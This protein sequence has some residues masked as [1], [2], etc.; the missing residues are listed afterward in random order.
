TN[1]AP[2]AV[3]PIP[4]QTAIE[5]QP[6]VNTLSKDTFEDV[7]IGDD[8]TI[9]AL[10]ENG[11]H[12]PDWLS[13]DPIARSFR[14][15]PT[16]ADVGTLRIKVVAT[17][18]AG[19]TAHSEFSMSVENVNDAPVP[20]LHTR[21]METTENE[22]FVFALPADAFSD[23]DAQDAFSLAATLA[24]GTALPDWLLF[25]AGTGALS[26]TPPIGA[27]GPVELSIAAT[28]CAGA[29][30]ALAFRIIVSAAAGQL[31]AGTSDMDT[32][33]G[34]SG[35]DTLNG[36]DGMDV[37][38]GLKGDD[39]YLVD[40][41]ADQVV[42]NDGE[43]ND[44]ILASDTY[45]LPGGVENLTLMG[46]CGGY[47]AGNALD[48][49]LTGNDASNV[50]VGDGGADV[51]LG[52][53]GSDQLFCGS[54][55]DVA[56]GGND[57]DILFGET[58][59]DC[60]FGES[61]DDVVFGD[62]GDDALDG[63]DG[64]D[65]LFG[66]AGTDLLVGGLDRDILYGDAGNDVLEGGDGDDWIFDVDGNNL[67]LA[68]AGT[69][70][71]TGGVSAEVFI[72]EAGADVVTTG[73]G[74]DVIVFNRGDGQDALISEGDSEKTLSLGGGIA[75]GDLSLWKA[76]G[77]LVVEMGAG[78]SIR[79]RDWYS[80]GTS[81]RRVIALQ[82]VSEAM[83]GFDSEAADP[84]VARRVNQFDFIGL[85]DAFDGE[86][87]A[88]PTLDRWTVARALTQFHLGGSDEAALG[89]DLA[90]LYGRDG[91][92]GG[93]GSWAAQE[94]LGSSQMGV[95][96]QTVRARMELQ[97]GDLRLG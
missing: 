89:G 61:G 57:V 85:V 19:S 28:D 6:Y 66:G 10:L 35:N 51:L 36:G 65:Q 30:G 31:L 50:L 13:F 90:Y 55:N 42:E 94:V 76:D 4:T 68:G 46:A 32:L 47:G 52:M 12:L 44:T 45:A 92:L 70:A 49:L 29:T 7:D 67:F 54:G 88:N 60:L 82:L 38:I 23:P 20:V 26:G 33:T 15:T 43:G 91:T 21:D 37:L 3:L 22:P 81:G 80:A 5:D 48:N 75:Y 86:R 25:D 62:E 2:F 77:D 71:L 95:Q 16:N 84:L 18:R 87:A 27:I 40:S 59:R 69:D 17:D 83:A 56:H 93:V 24:D 34:M 72:G 96:P 1:D 53:G 39:I 97:Q 8:P 41:A 64:M 78:D 58:G 63:G 73:D 9:S 74:A 79:L 11:N 14:G